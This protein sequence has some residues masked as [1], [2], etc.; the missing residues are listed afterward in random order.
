MKFSSL[1]QKE[2]LDAILYYKK[3]F[4]VSKINTK[5]AILR[6]LYYISGIY[7]NEEYEINKKYLKSLKRQKI[8]KYKQKKE[9]QC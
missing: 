8:K 3:L 4:Y 2:F 6:N 7:T 9:G 1:F 5:F